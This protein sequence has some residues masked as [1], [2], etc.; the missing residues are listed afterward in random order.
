MER[1][2]LVT[3]QSADGDRRALTIK[4]T[5]QGRDAF[6]QMAPIHAEWIVEIFGE[7]PAAEKKMLVHKLDNLKKAMNATLSTSL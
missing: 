3:R 7:L 6:A 1:R 2:G 5:D 4:L